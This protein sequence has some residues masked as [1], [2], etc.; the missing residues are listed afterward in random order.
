MLESHFQA[1]HATRPHLGQPF[2]E[3]ANTMTSTTSPAALSPLRTAHIDDLHAIVEVTNRAFVCEQ[4]CVAGDRTDAA[5]IRQRFAAGSFFVVAD[6]AD[7]SRL[8]GSVFCAVEKSRGYL[9]LLSV[10][11]DAQGLGLAH[12]LVAAVEKHC[13]AAGCN[14]LDITVVNVRDELFPF[15]AKLGFAAVDVLPFP[16]PERALRPLLLVKMTKPLRAPTQMTP[17]S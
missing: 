16:V 7:A 10:H 12:V 14:F 15:Y 9:G 1:C 4:F 13:R 3:H 2:I 5:D 17:Q 8:H 6:L 11:P